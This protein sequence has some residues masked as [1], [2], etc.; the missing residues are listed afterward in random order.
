MADL[1]GIGVEQHL[2]WVKPVSRIVDVRDESDR[3]SRHPI[4]IVCPVRSPCPVII[5]NRSR[6]IPGDQI[7]DGESRRP[8]IGG[9]I[10]GQREASL[11]HGSGSLI[12][13]PHL[14]AGS[15]GGKDGKRNMSF[16]RIIGCSQ[17]LGAHCQ[18]SIPV[19]LYPHQS[20]G[21]TRER[22]PGLGEIAL[23]GENI[24]C[25]SLER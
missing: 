3:T 24:V 9:W 10:G 12:V 11:L 22:N 18:G 6:Q 5:V 8:E 19:R 25:T 15:P 16:I 14:N 17:V 1:E 7:G 4:R 23:R 13:K 2:V 20:K 21:Q